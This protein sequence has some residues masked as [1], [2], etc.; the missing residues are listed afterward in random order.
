MGSSTHLWLSALK[1]ATLGLELQVSVGPR[2][3]LLFLQ[4]KQRLLDQIN[5]SLWVT[6]MTGHFVHE[7]ARA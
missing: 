2:P 5:M 3:H 4:A 7:K 1:T 6:D